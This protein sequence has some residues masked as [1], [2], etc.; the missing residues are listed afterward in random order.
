MHVADHEGPPST[1]DTT[2]A[3]GSTIVVA[4]SVSFLALIIF[5]GIAF[6]LG[7]GF[8]AYVDNHALATAYQLRQHER[9]L[10]PIMSAATDLGSIV[11]LTLQT[12][13]G[14]VILLWRKARRWQQDIVLLLMAICGAG[15]LNAGLKE[16]FARARPDLYPGPY[17]LSSYSFPSG[18]SMASAAFYG[19]VAWI[20][21]RHTRR[22]G[23]KWL[24]ALAAA[25]ITML[26][27]LSRMYF[28][29]HYP[30]DVFGG[31]VAGAA[32]VMAVDAVSS[33]WRWRLTRRTTV[34][35]QTQQ[36]P[37]RAT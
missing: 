18:H 24:I 25:I 33:V 31:F 9:W 12:V 35:H 22:R 10:D 36:S 26:I 34:P 16:L 14:L 17:Q 6:Y 37:D 19:T 3:A 23:L 27:G 20:I 29:V 2:L 32:W 7:E 1:G 5:A 4:L 13:L 30:S 15:L 21:A 28:S 11:G 8:V